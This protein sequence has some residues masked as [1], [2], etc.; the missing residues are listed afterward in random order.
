MDGLTA[1]P[2]LPNG[3]HQNGDPLPDCPAGEQPAEAI[4][5]THLVRRRVGLVT[6]RTRA[7]VEQK[8]RERS[9][10][11]EP[12]LVVRAGENL[13]L[14]RHAA[15]GEL[16]GQGDVRLPVRIALA[17]LD[18]QRNGVRPQARRDPFGQ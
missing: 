18:V 7:V 3:I 5:Y 16:P 17:R 13:E 2:L 11:A 9:H 6:E 14:A 1:I 15:A 10:L 8:H 4:P 12:R